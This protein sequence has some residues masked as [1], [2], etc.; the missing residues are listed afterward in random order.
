[1]YITGMR[2]NASVDSAFWAVDKRL[3]VVWVEACSGA[4]RLLRDAGTERYRI[5][6]THG[7]YHRIREMTMIS[8]GET[9]YI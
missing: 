3:I 7:N 5:R 9:C 2:L 1:M 4:R 6:D 8:G